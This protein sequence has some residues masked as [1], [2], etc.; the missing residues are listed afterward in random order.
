MVE[1]LV[2]VPGAEVVDALAA[3]DWAAEDGAAELVVEGGTDDAW[4][5]EA[6]EADADA[7][8]EA[9]DAE[10]LGGRLEDEEG[11]TEDDEDDGGAE[12]EEELGG[13]DEVVEDE[14]AAELEEAGGAEE[15]AEEAVEETIAEA[16]EVGGAAEEDPRGR[17][18]DNDIVVRGFERAMGRALFSNVLRMIDTRC[19]SDTAK[20]KWEGE[21]SVQ[22]IPM[23]RPTGRS[24]E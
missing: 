12:D 15:A 9:D 2:D 13:A 24:Q 8:A 5:A 17:P 23:P 6:E 1:Y 18:I 4:L 20:M 21:E 11:G 16:E 14:T 3:E 22:I 7:E 10:E 19:S